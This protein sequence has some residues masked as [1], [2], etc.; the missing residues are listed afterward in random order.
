[1]HT[2]CRLETTWQRII[3][4]VDVCIPVMVLSLS[5][6][7]MFVPDVVVRTMYFTSTRKWYDKLEIFCRGI[8]LLGL[9]VPEPMSQ[10]RLGGHYLGFHGTLSR[11]DKDTLGAC[12]PLA[13]TTTRVGAE[14]L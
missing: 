12:I 11:H 13:T 8:A 7:T 4:A 14:E 5:M 6:E 2:H 3:L 1:M 9:S 10:W